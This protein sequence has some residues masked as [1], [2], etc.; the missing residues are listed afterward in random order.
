MFLHVVDVAIA[1]NRINPKKCYELQLINDNN[2]S[3]HVSYRKCFV[4]PSKDIDLKHTM[5]HAIVDQI[6]EF[7]K[8]VM[9]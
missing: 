4:K 1:Y 7:K 2:I 8:I 6:L 3:Q 5:R 9:N